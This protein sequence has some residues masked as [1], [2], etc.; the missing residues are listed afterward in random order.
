MGIFDKIH[1]KKSA[2][3]QAQIRGA[4]LFK[5]QERQRDKEYWA[6]QKAEM[7]ATEMH[8]AKL[9]R[10]RIKEKHRA[11]FVTNLDKKLMGG[12]AKQIK[13]APRPRVAYRYKKR[14][15]SF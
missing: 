12:I 9:K 4:K 15:Y 3:Q 7:R 14:T 5:Q 2:H 13:P 8:S 1:V 6:N 11:D 10:L